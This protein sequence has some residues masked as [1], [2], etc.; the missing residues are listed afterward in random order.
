M[1]RAFEFRKARKFKRWAAM[2]KTFTR[3]GKEIAMAVKEGGPDPDNNARLR[4]AIQ[5][6]KSSNMPLDT[7]DRAIKKASSKDQADY[8]EVNFEGYAPHGI[9]VFVET[10]TDNNTRTVAN[11]R[12]YFNKC[13]GSLGTT[14]SLEFLFDRKCNFKIDKGEL[15]PEELELEMIDYGIEELF[16]EDE[17]IMI[18]GEFSEFGNIQRGLE[19][20]GLP[21]VESGYERLPLN[22]TELSED[23]QADVEKLLERLEEDDDVLNVYHT[24]L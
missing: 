21:V 22:T 10:A 15:D 23:Q 14:G 18:Y 3:I 1:G 16:E 5:N 11:V 17:H 9:A 20:L 24:M 19:Q 7:V 4:S 2:S 13:N 8:K 12:S 6:A